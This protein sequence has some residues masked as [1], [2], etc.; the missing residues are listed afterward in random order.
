MFLADVHSHI[1]YGVDDGAKSKAVMLQMLDSAYANGVRA[2]CVTPHYNPELFDYVPEEEDKAFEELAAYAKEKYP[3]LALY[4][5]NEVYVFS[6]VPSYVTESRRGIFSANKKL[7]VEFSVNTTLS[8]IVETV[9]GLT[10]L[11]YESVLAHIE[12]YRRISVKNVAALK[13]IGATVTVNAESV[14][15]KNGWQVKR[16]VAKLIK[17]GLVNIVSSDAHAPRGYEVFA[18]AHKFVLDK[19]GEAVAEQLFWIN[20][21]KLF[22]K[23]IE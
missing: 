16:H 15:G 9:S 7:L 22:I 14:V 19:Y 11:G 6:G 1:L 18:E 13:S 12:R 17:R 5:W 20:S 10:S 2:L 3:D 4:R 8:D 21:N 23:E